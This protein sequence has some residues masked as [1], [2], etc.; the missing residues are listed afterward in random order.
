MENNRLEKFYSY[1]KKCVESYLEKLFQISR[2]VEYKL[3]NVKITVTPCHGFLLYFSFPNLLDTIFKVIKDNN[4]K[5]L[6]KI[7]FYIFLNLI[8]AR[9]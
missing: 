2:Y 6:Q 4:S 5:N 7:P 3:W 1:Q 8:S 9:N